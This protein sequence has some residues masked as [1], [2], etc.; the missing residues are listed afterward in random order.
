[1][2]KN[3]LVITQCFPCGSWVCIE[4]I[5]EKL[6][7]RKYVVTI[8]GLSKP[9]EINSNFSYYTIPYLAYTRFG[10]LTCYSP[11]LGFI[12]M[13]PLYVSA[14]LL[15]VFK[16]PKVIIYNGLTLG[17]VIAPFFR[18]L[19][20]KNIIMYHSIIKDTG[21]ITKNI[22]KI[23][24]KSIDLVVV[25][26]TGMRDDLVSVVDNDRLIVNEHYADSVFF[27]SPQKKQKNSNVLNVLYAGRIDVDKRCFPLID[28]AKRMKNNPSYEFTFVGG[29]S[30]V[31]KV[32][33]LHKEYKHIKYGGYIDDKKKLAKLYSEADV[34]W[35]FADTT[36]LCLPAVEALAC[37]TPIIIPQ[38]AA[39]INKDELIN[40]SLVPES[41]G[42]LVDSFSQKDIED[43]FSTIQIKKE[44]L[45]KECKMY[46]LKYY[47]E[48]NL[49][50]TVSE[51]EKKIEKI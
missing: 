33:N 30:D 24:F 13:V 21:V 39:I 42:W 51:I 19:G 7:R 1:M 11:I 38:Y 48:K 14:V 4:K 6:S 8:L 12:W 20:K 47:S 26:S 43:L 28:F 10:N 37:G 25:N 2:N 17:L 44:Y 18:L 45:K 3:I 46:A 32:S 23:L 27:S 34:L 5:V 29:G 40:K 15:G 16:N 22:L 49:L 9:T 36:Y 31:G 50:E 41:I 35:G